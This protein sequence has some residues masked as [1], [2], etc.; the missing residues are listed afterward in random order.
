MASVEHRINHNC[1]YCT[2]VPENKVRFSGICD[3]HL[4]QYYPPQAKKEPFVKKAKSRG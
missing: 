4:D 2:Y 1:D 3:Y